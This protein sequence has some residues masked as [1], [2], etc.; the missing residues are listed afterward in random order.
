MM[1]GI[2]PRRAVDRCERLAK[3]GPPPPLSRPWKL[4]RWLR[5]YR[6]IMSLDI[7]EAAEMLRGVYTDEKLREI[8]T[9]P[10][11]FTRIAMGPVGRATV[12]R[13]VEPVHVGGSIRYHGDDMEVGKPHSLLPRGAVVTSI[14]RVTGAV[15]YEVP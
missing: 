15:T 5:D 2:V 8:A 11:P 4:R 9:A 6:A 10:N 13:W 7:S 14:D 1:L 12:G 3:L